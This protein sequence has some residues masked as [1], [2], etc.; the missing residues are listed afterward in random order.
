MLGRAA[1]SISVTAQT[2][3]VA[4][5]IV[6]LLTK[7]SPTKDPSLATKLTRKV[8]LIAWYNLSPANTKATKG[9]PIPESDIR[10]FQG[11]RKPHADLP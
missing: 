7:Y 10:D 2:R 6:T 3:T 11:Q 4:T 1:D 5:T 8:Q 9:R